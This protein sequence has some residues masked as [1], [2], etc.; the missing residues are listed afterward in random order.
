MTPRKPRRDVALDVVLINPGSRTRIYQS[1]SER[2]PTEYDR[3]HVVV[4]PIR[5]YFLELPHS[6]A[7]PA[8]LHQQRTEVVTRSQRLAVASSKGSL[9]RGE[10]GFLHS[11]RVLLAT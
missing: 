9:L 8:E 10:R 3:P 6:V 7:S 4:T 2:Y 1:L 11:D 5:D